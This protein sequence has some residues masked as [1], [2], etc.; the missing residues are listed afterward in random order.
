MERND[1]DTVT[2]STTGSRP[3]DVALPGVNVTLVAGPEAPHHARHAASDALAHW[4]TE[5]RDAA[6]LV[7]SEL[8]TNAVRHGTRDDDDRIAL[9]VRRR[10]RTTRIEVTDPRARDGSVAESAVD[11]E[12]KRAGW[13]LPIVSELTDRWGVERG[14]GRTCVWCEIDHG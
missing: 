9:V 8:V 2:R 3:P 11:R 12:E 4:T 6:L 1:R 5:R 13:G 10:G 7:I 14:A